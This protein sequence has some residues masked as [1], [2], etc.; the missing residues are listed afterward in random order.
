MLILLLVGGGVVALIVLVA[1]IAMLASGSPDTRSFRLNQ[2]EAK[3]W[4]ITFKQN[5][6]VEIWV[7]SN[8]NTDVDLFVYNS[9]GM[10]VALDEGDSKDCYVVF[11]AEDTQPYKVEVQNRV[12]VDQPQRNGFNSGTMRYAETAFDGQPPGKGKKK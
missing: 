6:K 11:I 3:S 1:V 10:P 5:H 12:R 7:T 9:M 8:N 4:N 2:G